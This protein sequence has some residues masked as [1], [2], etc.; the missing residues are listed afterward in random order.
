MDEFAINFILKEHMGHAAEV[1][2]G[3]RV[4]CGQVMEIKQ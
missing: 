2:A 1:L 3:G 4:Y